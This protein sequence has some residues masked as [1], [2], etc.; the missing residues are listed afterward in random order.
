[1]KEYFRDTSNLISFILGSILSFVFFIFKPMADVPFWLLFLVTSLLF[2]V[3]WL[4]IKSRIDLHE[5]SPSPSIQIIECTHG[6]CLCKPNNLIVL[7]SFVVFSKKTGEYEE[8]FAFGKV[9]SITQKGVAQ[10]KVYPLTE[11]NNDVPR[12]DILSYINDEKSNILVFPT[13]TA[14]ILQQINTII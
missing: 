10:I 2:I 7:S 9:E 12:T 3:I 4:L 13:I 14:D 6:V 8:P 11:N 1:M 5:A